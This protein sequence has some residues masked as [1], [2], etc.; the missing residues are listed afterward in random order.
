M[1]DNS[2]MT[3]I[4]YS[5]FLPYWAVLQT[6][7]RQTVRSWVYRLWVLL[8]IIAASASILYKFGVHRD[9]GIVQ[10]A[11]VQTGDLMRGL[12]VGSLGLI[13]L[14]AVSSI[15]AERSSIADSVLCRGI[16]R[17]QY[18]LAKWHARVF[19]IIC[20]FLAMSTIVLAAHHFLFDSDITFLGSLAACGLAV[21]ILLV[22]ISWGVTVGALS[23]STLIGIT[24]FWILLYTGII[25][26]SL[27]PE[28]YPAPDRMLTK[29]KFILQGHFDSSLVWRVLMFAGGLSLLAAIVGL[30][31]FTRKDV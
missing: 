6:D 10:S 8:C 1:M 25:L 26:L 18:F 5:R 31:G 7:L 16:S 23:N 4:R 3:P 14:L 9:A 24:L 28:P 29:L 20:T 19:V 11:S 27:L 22:V 13:A 15:S 12:V 30:I 17:H 21:G 2:S